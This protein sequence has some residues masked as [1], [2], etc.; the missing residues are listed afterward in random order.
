M[1]L[2]PRYI[3]KRIGVRRLVFVFITASTS[4][5]LAQA[6]RQGKFVGWG[7]G[8]AK[9]ILCVMTE[10]NEGPGDV[11]EPQKILVLSAFSWENNEYSGSSWL[12]KREGIY[13]IQKGLI[14]C[15]PTFETP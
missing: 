11:A 4:S 6:R 8:R 15:R 5:L 2:M 14:I 9:T 12:S 1:L 3:G 13:L 7:Q 10:R